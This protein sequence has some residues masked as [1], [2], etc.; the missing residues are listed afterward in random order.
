MVADT[1]FAPQAGRQQ[2]Q[3]GIDIRAVQ[4]EHL[5]PELVKLAITSLLGPLVAEHGPDVPHPAFLI[6]EQAVFDAGA[7]ATGRA[8]GAQ[9]QAVAIAR[10]TSY[11]VCYTKLL[12]LLSTA[13]PP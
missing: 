7:H 2:D 3:L 5:D 9:G 8:L 4:A 1:E 10:I 11:N 6:V 12:R 13:N